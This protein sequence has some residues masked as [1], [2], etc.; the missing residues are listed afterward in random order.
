[1]RKCLYDKVSSW[2]CVDGCRRDTGH[3]VLANKQEVNIL[4][5]QDHVA[6]RAFTLLQQVHDWPHVLDCRSHDNNSRASN[7]LSSVVATNVTIMFRN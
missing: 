2:F 6:R 4:D 7:I 3:W 1:M 5:R